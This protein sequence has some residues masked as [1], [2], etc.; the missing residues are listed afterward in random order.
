MEG[1]VHI[2]LIASAFLKF[3]NTFKKF[4]NPV[5]GFVDWPNTNQMIISIP[6]GYQLCGFLNIYACDIKNIRENMDGYAGFA[7][8]QE[9]DWLILNRAGKIFLDFMYRQVD[10]EVLRQALQI[11]FCAIQTTKRWFYKINCMY[12]IKHARF[13]EDVD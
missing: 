7:K 12:S 11:E 8:G 13:M 3:E 5:S 2:T 1:R 6:I 10:F 9:V 4:I